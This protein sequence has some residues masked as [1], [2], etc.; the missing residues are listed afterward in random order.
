M[1][2]DKNTGRADFIFY[3][4][5]INRL[6]VEEALNHLPVLPHTVTTPVGRTYAGVKFEGKICGVSIMRAG[7]AS[8]SIIPF[9]NDT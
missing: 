5:R 7:E 8:K 2:R 3:S 6:L 1:I 4:N 9:S